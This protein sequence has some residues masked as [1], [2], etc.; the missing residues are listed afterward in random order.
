MEINHPDARQINV[1]SSY[2]KYN[3][4]GKQ[5]EVLLSVYLM[6]YLPHTFCH[7]VN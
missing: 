4:S 7:D 5:L 1:L 6:V 2:M 3:I